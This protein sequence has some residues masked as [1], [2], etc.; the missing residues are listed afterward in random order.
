MFHWWSA[1]VA[2]GG[3]ILLSIPR[4]VLDLQAEVPVVVCMSSQWGRCFMASIK[5][6]SAIPQTYGLVCICDMNVFLAW[7][8]FSCLKIQYLPW[9]VPFI[10]LPCHAAQ[11]TFTIHG[12]PIVYLGLSHMCLALQ[13]SLTHCTLFSFITLIPAW[14]TF[15][16]LKLQYLLQPVPPV[17]FP[18]HAAQPTCAGHGHPIVYPGL[19]LPCLSETKYLPQPVPPVPRPSHAAQPIL[20]VYGH[21]MVLVSLS[22]IY[23]SLKCGL[24]HST[25][26]YHIPLIPAWP[27]YAFLVVPCMQLSAG[28]S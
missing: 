22:H 12:H 8:T 13:C 17:P 23:L 7:P 18:Y 1:W 26:F 6:I 9:P 14:P 25:L 2:D 20:T 24:T 28:T 27:I 5:S 15:A 19:T 11:P 16:C 4:P 3:C 21:S 10:P